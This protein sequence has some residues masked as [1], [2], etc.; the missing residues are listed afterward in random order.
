MAELFPVFCGLACEIERRPAPPLPEAE[1]VAMKTAVE[2]RKSSFAAGRTAARKALEKFGLPDAVIPAGTDR[3]PSWPPGMTGSISH[4][5]G[6]AVAVAARLGDLAAV[7]VD[8]ERT[9]AVSRDLWPSLLVAGEIRFLNSSARAEQDRLATVMFSIKEAFFK[10]QYPHTRKWIDFR[11]V[12]IELAVE[13]DAWTLAPAMPVIIAG[14]TIGAL[15]GHYRVGDAFTL[16]A[17]Y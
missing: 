10:Y 17:A 13:A 9:A 16:A 7:G 1:A 3:A 11:E 6:L 4:A 2:A 14:K 8:L 5:G 12:E 15:R